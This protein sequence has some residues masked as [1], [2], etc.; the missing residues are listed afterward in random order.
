MHPSAPV[1]G[2]PPQP[3][4]LLGPE[5]VRGIAAQA[6][7]W[8]APAPARAPLGVHRAEIFLTSACNLSCRYCKS[9]HRQV[10]AW[11]AADVRALLAELA[12]GG[13]QH[14]QWTGGEATLHPALLA[15][16][17]HATDLGL[18]NSISTNGTA[19][20]ALYEALFLAG[21]GRFY[22]SLDVL[23]PA[24]L[25]RERGIEGLLPRVQA[26]V[27]RLCAGSAGRRPHVTIN[28]VL[29]GGTVRALLAREGAELRRLLAWC[30][31]MGVDDFKFLPVAT[32]HRSVSFEG[33]EDWR[34]FEAICRAEVPERYPMFH[35]RLRSL[36]A[37]GHG[38]GGENPH[39][40]W[41]C[42]DD[43]AFDALGAWPCII[44][45]REGCAPLWTHDAPAA[46]R[47]AALAAFLRTDRRADPVCRTHCFD[48]YRDLSRAV[49]LPLTPQG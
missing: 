22:F 20:P 34:R 5:R 26:A 18:A 42:L 31:G 25:A 45:M 46:E 27:T 32:A 28:S 47:R 3:G 49:T 13:A 7:A 14:I 30:Q 41:F 4:Y 17:Q 33:E 11:E 39:T 36:A 44:R 43:R 38:L 37:G 29:D 24:T 10:P 6:R 23:D 2:D 35:H 8:S 12:A 21:M 1:R 15:L 48:L 40:C 9:R 16:V 19:P